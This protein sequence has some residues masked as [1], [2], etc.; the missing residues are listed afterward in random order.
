MKTKTLAAPAGMSGVYVE[1][2]SKGEIYAVAANWAQA[3]S[4]VMV[5]GDRG[6][7]LDECGRQVAD[8]RHKSHEALRDQ[9][10]RAIEASGDE[11]DAD[12]VQGI[13][14]DAAYLIDADVADIMDVLDSYGDRFAGNDAEDTANG[15]I[16]DGITNPEIV[17]EWC[18]IGVWESS[19]AAR[20]IE[21]NLTPA[22]VS[23]GAE[24]ML[25]N[26]G[27]DEDSADRYTDGSPIYS[28]C[29][30]DTSIDDLIEA[31]KQD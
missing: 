5:Y 31:S 27:E 23:A 8:F 18:E 22:Q 6:W 21:E 7:T 1:P 16:N 25:E 29:N 2:W 12:E 4:P 20:M 30:R 15:W 17:G 3:S 14:D 9:I 11:A 28:V 13:I 26:L 19:V 10:V 24:R